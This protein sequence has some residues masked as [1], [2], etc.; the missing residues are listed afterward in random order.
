[1]EMTVIL[2]LLVASVWGYLLGA[3]PTGVLVCRI[4]RAP[5][6]HHNGSRHTGG[7][8]VARL[9]GIWAGALT[10]A[11]DILLG[12]GAVAGA[13]LLTG[14]PWAAAAAGVMAVVGH[15]WS[16]FIGFGGGIGLS[17]LFGGLV[18]F[19]PLPALA[20]LIALAVLWFALSRLLHL[21]RARATILTMAAV[22]P[23]LWALGFSWPCILLGVLGGVVVIL[24]TLPDLNREYG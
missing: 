24:K 8:N 4:V 14:S 12:F 18:G 2:E 16:V 21:H 22:G 1:M 5:D 17:S 10:A 11:I 15:N 6:A 7:S 13:A 23:L 3:V 19:A 9:A 20:A